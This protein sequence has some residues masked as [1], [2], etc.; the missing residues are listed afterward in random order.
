M[1]YITTKKNSKIEDFLK[2]TKKELNK[3]FNFEIQE[4]AVMLLNSREQIN[5]IWEQKT[6]DWLVGGAKILNGTKNGII[7]IL[8]PDAFP[9][10]S[11]HKKEEFWQVLKHEYCH[12]YFRQI[13]G[14]SYPLWL[15]EGLANYLAGQKKNGGNPLDV[16]SYF[17]EVGGGIYN[18]GYYWVEFLIKKFG[19]KKMVQLIHGLKTEREMTPRLFADI[20]QNIYGFKFNRRELT[21]VLNNR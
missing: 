17:D 10:Y 9:K 3:F 11:S 1:N 7:F 4:P 12:I 2:T 13:T 20:F 15:N 5:S 6:A 21:I 19:K 8:S 16:F 14:G 18:V